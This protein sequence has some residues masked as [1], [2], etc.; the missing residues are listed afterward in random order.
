MDGTSNGQSPEAA[1]VVHARLDRARK[2]WRR[3]DVAAVVLRGAVVVLAAFLAALA[4]DNLLRLPGFV[5]LVLGLAFVTGAVYFLGFKV[6]LRLTR[7]LTDEM[8]AAHVER[9]HPD[10]DNYLINAILLQK[11]EF[12]DPIT[13]RMATSQLGEAARAVDSL[14]PAD[15]TGCKGLRKWA[16]I[17]GGLCLAS[18]LYAVALPAYFSNALQRYAAPQ[19]YIPAVSAVNL[20]VTPGNADRLQGDSLVVEA[21]GP[22]S[23]YAR[24]A[25]ITFEDRASGRRETKPMAFEGGFFSYE[26]AGLQ[27]DF[28]Y[29]VSAGDFVS[30]R[31]AVTVR[32]RPGVREVKLTYVFPAYMNLPDQVEPPSAIGNI[33]API[34]TRVR[35]EASAD[36]PIKSARL[37]VGTMDA[38]QWT[39]TPMTVAGGQAAQGEIE[40]AHSGRYR[41]IVQD[42]AD[43]PNQPVVAQIV[44]LPDDPPVVRVTD[45]GKDITLDTSAKLTVSA[46]AKDDFSLQGMAFFI[47]RGADKEWEKVRTWSYK[48]TSRETPEGVALDLKPLNLSAG[49]VLSY[50]FQAS[51]GMPG[52]DATAGRSRVYQVTIG[53][54]AAVKRKSE[55]ALEALR[56]LITR[57]IAMQKSNLAATRDVRG[58]AESGMEAAAPPHGLPDRASPLRKAEEEIYS[59][60]IQTVRA[61]AENAAVDLLDGLSSIASREVVRAVDELEA[62][63][64][65]QGKA[66]ALPALDTAAATE[67]QIAELLEKL[68]SDP[69]AF[70]R[71]RLTVPPK[72]RQADQE[73]VLHGNRERAERMLAAVKDFIKEQEDVVKMSKQ[74][75]DTPV[76]DFSRGDEENLKKVSDSEL[77]WAK[78]FQELATDLSKL[79]PQDFSLA[80]QAKEFN[81]IYTDVQKAADAADQKAVEMAVPLEQSGLELAKSL[82][83]NIE[84]W[85]AESPDRIAWKM[86]DP[87]QDYDVP[88]AELPKELE[89]LIGDLLEQEQDLLDDAADATSAWLD[90]M[91]KGVGWGAADGPIADM[92]AKGVTGNVLPDSQEVGGRSGEGRTGKSSGQYVQDTASGK[93]GRNTPTRLTLD[94]YEA[95]SVKDSSAESPS[96]STGGGKAS[97][98]GQEGL[99]GP[100]PPT[101]RGELKRVTQLQQQL[102]DKAQSLDYGLRKYNYPHGELPKT[103]ELMKQI[104]TSIE[105][106]DIPT[107]GTSSRIVL[108]NL[109][110]L[111]DVVSRQ[112]RLTRDNSASLPKEIRDEIAAGANEGVPQEY[113]DLVSGYFRA[114]SEAGTGP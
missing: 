32:T 34:G 100:M 74:L 97:G 31:Y 59:T 12:A 66:Q 105:Q 68:L 58:W 52:R 30:D 103:I 17:A 99:R 20:T 69:Q 79:P 40:V 72:T 14:S 9:S 23:V 3:M 73:E 60:A 56:A 101:V 91:D 89:D 83:T 75:K 77:K 53:D 18:V 27:S 41:I 61:N 92:S 102:I 84:K 47:Q 11:A 71:E 94:P 93:G 6:L 82:E 96:G 81:E 112:K 86:E 78:Y 55:Q 35:I 36:R 104:Q 42:A 24:K 10:L 2:G 43:V 28:N 39:D 65:A 67:Q 87:V 90:N 29:R 57:L 109:T 51:D 44:A 21:R 37:S 110:E 50:Y 113:R 85:L 38:A 76:N 49:A 48:A 22:A 114:L 98:F 25:E 13:R 7:R 62:V 19:K 26:F 63:R 8:V 108:S 1:E 5:R 16:L 107:A 70:A 95:G 106:G 33:T 15:A 88:L 46:V 64:A 80:T 45:P 54:A 111:K 4:L